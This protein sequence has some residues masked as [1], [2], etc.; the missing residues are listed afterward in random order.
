MTGVSGYEQLARAVLETACL[1]FHL[2]R[3]GRTTSGRL[4][5]GQWLRRRPGMAAKAKW[6]REDAEKFFFSDDSKEIRALWFYVAGIA[7]VSIGDWLAK[8]I[9]ARGEK[10]AYTLEFDDAA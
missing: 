3:P 7:P 9:D 1:D 5:P 4:Y 8:E 2:G 10:V 6:L